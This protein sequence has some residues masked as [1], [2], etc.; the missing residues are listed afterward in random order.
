MVLG[1]CSS[2]RKG[3]LH[4]PYPYFLRGPLRDQPGPYCLEELVAFIYFWSLV[5]ELGGK[6]A[7]IGVGGDCCSV[8][9]DSCSIRLQVRL[10][11][12][13]VKVLTFFPT[14][15]VPPRDF[16]GLLLTLC[17]TITPCRAQDTICGAGN[18][19]RV[20]H[21]HGQCINSGT[22]SLVLSFSMI[23]TRLNRRCPFRCQVIS[24][25]HP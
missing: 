6:M 12:W 10:G 7:C 23:H 11:A 18:Q 19:T 20:S 16:H 24:L 3:I 9:G 14:L 15:K 21:L 5:E 25:H 4:P 1:F 17:S 22:V 8:G 2:C 13:R